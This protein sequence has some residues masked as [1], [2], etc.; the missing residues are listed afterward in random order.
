MDDIHCVVCPGRIYEDRIHLFFECNFSRRVWNYLQIVWDRNG[1][2]GLQT[3][4]AK[5]RRSFWTSF[6]ME[7]LIAPCWNIWLI[8]NAKIF[9]GERHTFARWKGLLCG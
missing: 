2:G 6:F 3:I 8:Q 4:I 1:M 9:K 7:V 5:A